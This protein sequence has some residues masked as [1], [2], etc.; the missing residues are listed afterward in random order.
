M[1]LVLFDDDFIQRTSIVIFF[2]VIEHPVHKLASIGLYYIY[3]Y[4]YVFYVYLPYFILT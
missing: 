1:L 4:M 3:I 2:K